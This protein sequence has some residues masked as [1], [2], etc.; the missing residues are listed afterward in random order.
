MNLVLSGLLYGV[1]R[2][3]CNYRWRYTLRDVENMKLFEM[4]LPGLGFPLV[5]IEIFTM[6]VFVRM[7][8]AGVTRRARPG[9]TI[10]L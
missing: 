7:V 9:R 8:Y 4:P 2:D 3:R 1:L 6:Y 10:A 5:A